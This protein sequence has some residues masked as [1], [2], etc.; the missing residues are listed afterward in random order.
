ML[1]DVKR[2]WDAF[3]RTDPLWSIFTHPPYKGNK[4][5]VD[6][7]FRTGEHLVGSIIKEVEG[8]G[9]T[10][11]GRCLDFGCG[12]GRLTQ[13]LCNYFERCDGVDIAPSMIDLARKFNRHPD[14]CQYHV[15]DAPDLRMFADN[16]FDFVLSWIVLQHMEPQYS[17]QYMKEFVRVLRPGGVAVFQVPSLFL[18]DPKEPEP[19]SAPRETPASVEPTDEPVMEMHCVPKGDVI[20]LVL[21]AGAQVLSCIQDRHCGEPFASYH[22]IVKQP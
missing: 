8:L 9:I 18:G 10:P 4:W 22:Y 13:A 19:C 3:G 7:F 16:C 17:K 15:N 21:K 20:N 1:S 6:E 12:V 14:R 11:R 2:N 5:N